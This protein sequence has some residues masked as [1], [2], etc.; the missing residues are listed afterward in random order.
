MVKPLTHDQIHAELTRAQLCLTRG[1][2]RLAGELLRRVAAAATGRQAMQTAELLLAARVLDDGTELAVRIAGGSRDVWNWV[3]Q[4]AGHMRARGLIDA[5]RREVAAFSSTRPTGSVERMRADIVQAFGLPAAYRDRSELQAERAR[6]LHQLQ[7]FIATYPPSVLPE[8]D[9]RADDF[10]WSN[11]N[12]AYQGENDLDAQSDYGDWLTRSLE[13]VGSQSTIPRVVK[14]RPV[15]AFV[16]SKWNECTL[17]WYFA[18]W[19]EHLCQ[20][21]DARLVHTPGARHD[22]LS[23]RLAAMSGGEIVLAESIETAAAQIRALDADVVLYPELGTDGF[24]FALAAHRLAPVQVCAWGHPVTSG[25]PTIDA[26]FSCEAMEPPEAATHYRE[27]LIGLPGIGTRYFSPSLPTGLSGRHPKLPTQGSLYLMPQAI[28]KWH[29][30]TDRHLVEIVRRDSAARFVMF[31]LRPPSPARLVNDRLVR[32]LREVAA[33]PEDHLIWLPECPRDQY[34]HINLSCDVMVD[35]PHWSGG[36]A[37]IDALLC[38]LPVVTMPGRFMRG[39][40]SLGMLRL[41]GCEELIA[42]SAE[43]LA[44]TA[45]ALAHD[46]SRRQTLS[47]KMKQGF[48]A[49]TQSVEALVALDVFLRKLIQSP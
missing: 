47:E 23:Q 31:E 15:I 48:E 38:G 35:T 33:R 28:F 2:T 3:N 39:R 44:D 16:S 43:N 26:Y 32:A 27:R 22:S 40:Q 36:N 45:V 46:K 4:F 6:F 18:S 7:Q 10:A 41:L 9:A 29:P 20:S 49:L 17:G 5:S 37:T 12:L 42:E 24:T 30:D 19:V 25:L 21:W 11:F 8:I 13:Q 14:E 1:D 34:L